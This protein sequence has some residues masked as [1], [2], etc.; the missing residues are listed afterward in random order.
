MNKRMKEA[1]GRGFNQRTGLKVEGKNSD[2]WALVDSGDVVCS[3][4]Y[5]GLRTDYRR[6]LITKNALIICC[7]ALEIRTRY[8]KS[9]VFTITLRWR[10]S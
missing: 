5:F 10:T 3:C 6:L 2:E 9:I 7:A 1:L 4:T 8:I